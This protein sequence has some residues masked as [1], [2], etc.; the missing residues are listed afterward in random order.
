MSLMRPNDS[1]W[2]LF[3]PSLP[4]FADLS[5]RQLC[6]DSWLLIR[7][8]TDTQQLSDCILLNS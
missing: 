1:D 5:T 7:V 8:Q 6:V 2:V 4:L 3:V